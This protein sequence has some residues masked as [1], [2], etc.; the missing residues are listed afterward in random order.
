M[1]NV[2]MNAVQTHSTLETSMTICIARGD[3]KGLG[4]VVR[5]LERLPAE[6]LQRFLLHR[7]RN[8]P[9]SIV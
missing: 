2:E 5:E 3:E 6:D 8:V 9:R 7:A 4:A 1:Y